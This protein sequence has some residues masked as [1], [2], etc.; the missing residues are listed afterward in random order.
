MSAINTIL[1]N[2]GGKNQKALRNGAKD[3][4]GNVLVNKAVNS[5]SKPDFLTLTVTNNDANDAKYFCLMNQPHIDY[6]AYS[7]PKTGGGTWAIQTDNGNAGTGTF[8]F[9]P[10][11]SSGSMAGF[12]WLISHQKPYF[13]GFSMKVATDDK[14]TQFTNKIVML[15][16][17]YDATLPINLT[18]ENIAGASN[19]SFEQQT[20][21]VSRAFVLDEGN[22]IVFLLN[23]ATQ[24]SLVFNVVSF[25]N[26][27]RHQ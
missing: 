14:A 20:R 23:A 10:L 6:S 1:K 25:D 27:K 17:D 8:V 7:T 16:G 15:E 18:A 9:S 22:D 13:V 3:A 21:I 4:K 5:K 26:S 19:S 2:I 12:R 11:V 24:L